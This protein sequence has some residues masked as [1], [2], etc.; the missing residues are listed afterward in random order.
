MLTKVYLEGA[1]GERFGRE[2][3]FEI[4]SPS[5]A[6]KMVDANN[7]G[8]ACWLRMHAGKFTHYRVIVETEAGVES[9]LCEGSYQLNCKMK[10]VRFVPIIEGAGKFGNMIIGAIVVI[11]GVVY[12]IYTEDWAT[13][14]EIIQAGVN[15]M[16]VSAITALTTKTPKPPDQN[17]NY[18][19][20]NLVSTAFASTENTTEQGYPVP[21]I[22]GRCRVGSRVIS[23]CSVIEDI[24]II[25]EVV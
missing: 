3:E 1:L 5:E 17:Q 11:I 22:Y 7:P 15:M 8:V 10:S 24:S 21:V 19:A 18:E 9:A 4:N 2:W 13:A 16:A 6:L 14:A 12:G 25:E 20:K 23:S